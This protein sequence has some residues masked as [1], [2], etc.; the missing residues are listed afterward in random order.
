VE[1]A[2]GAIIPDAEIQAYQLERNATRTTRS[3]RDGLFRFVHLDPGSYEITV[4]DPRFNRFSRRLNLASGQG[5]EIVV[6]LVVSGT[7]T[8]VEVYAGSEA[9]ETARTAI[10]EYVAPREIDALPLNG[11]NYL[12]LALLVPGVSRTNTGAPQQ[13][14]ETSAV[15][16]TGI[17]FGGQRNLYNGFLLDGLSVNDDAAALV[18]TSFSQEVIREFQVLTGS[19]SAEFGRALG[20]TVS[21]ASRSGSNTWHGRTYGF[22]RNQRFDAR[23]PLATRK[24]PLTQSQYGVTLNGPLR[25]DR[26]FVF[27]NFEQG[28]RNAAGFITVAPVNVAS[29]NRILD[30]IG[31][32]GVRLTTGEFPTGIDTTNYFARVDHRVTANRQWMARYNLY[33]IGSPNSRSVGALNDLSRGTGLHNRDQTIAVGEVLVLSPSTVHELR[34]Q[35]TRSRLAAPANDWNGPAI[36][37]AGVANF[38]TSTGAPVGRDNDLYELN[39][40]LTVARNRLTVRAG[41][42]LIWN[43]LTI[44]FPGPAAAAVYSFSS[45]ANFEAGRYQTFQQAFGDTRQFQSNP[46]LGLYVET[47]SKIRPE[48]TLQIGLRW[49]V[50]KLP[51]PIRTDLNNLAPRTGFAWAPDR[52]TVVRASYGLFFDRVPL[53]ATSNALQRDGSRYRTALLAF[54]QP[55]APVFPAQLSSFPDGQF[56]N[57]TTIDP[58]IASS[59]SQ[60]ASLQIEREMSRNL[61]VSTGYQW[62]RG[63]HLILS[64]NQNVPTLTAVEANALGVPNLGRPDSHFGNVSRYEGSGDSY[65]HGMTVSLR[66]RVGSAVQT[67]L[68]YNFSKAID[69]TGN[70]FFST[71][72]DNFNLRGERGL[73]DNDQR[74]RITASAVFERWGYALAPIFTYTSTLPFNVLLGSDRNNDTNLNDRPLGVGR[75]TGPGFD[76]M[77]LDLRLSRRIHLGERWAMDLIAESFNTLN[78]S[79]WALPNATITSPSFGRATAANDPRQLQGAIRISF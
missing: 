26:T 32:P 6:S 25:Q 75:N 56:I 4:V 61:I 78:R 19:A 33:D 63:L 2:T 52:K 15:A 50:Q 34:G 38:G 27:S 18:G 1:D 9:M 64:R 72:Q 16:G 40:S 48:V 44:D 46:N 67:R 14:A 8:I 79:N 28:R 30:G 36:N 41:A 49:D 39:D 62:L 5:L 74:H 51:S 22:V 7:P 24:D 43:R 42:D 70:A 20:G 11:R 73:S 76:F 3:N 57:I 58:R 68:S 23:H 45:L 35:F 65:Y 69:N 71:P 60:Q 59:Y 53:R 77:S 66:A 17:S 13:F 54:G 12:D 55:G 21:I 37:I 10:A 31:F 29:I 47:E